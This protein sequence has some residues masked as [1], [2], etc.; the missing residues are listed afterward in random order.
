MGC[1]SGEY[2]AQSDGPMTSTKYT[3]DHHGEGRAVPGHV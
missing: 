2:A 1:R 3:T